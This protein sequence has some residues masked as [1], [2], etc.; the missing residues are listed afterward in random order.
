MVKSDWE[1]PDCQRAAAAAWICTAGDP[2][3]VAFAMTDAGSASFFSPRDGAAQSGEAGLESVSDVD[4]SVLVGY[5]AS[6]HEETSFV[7]VRPAAGTPEGS[8]R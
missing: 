5:A 3:S 2:A 4:L 8:Y 1:S 7:Q 6:H